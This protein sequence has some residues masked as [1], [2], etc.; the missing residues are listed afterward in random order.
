MADSWA[1]I[2]GKMFK[3]ALQELF[4]DNASTRALFSSCDQL[5]RAHSQLI[6]AEREFY[7]QLLLAE[8]CDVIKQGRLVN[9]FATGNTSNQEAL[10][11]TASV[12]AHDDK[13]DTVLRYEISDVVQGETLPH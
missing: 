5:I 7:Y 2:Y 12:G 1:C 10:E 11:S 9:Q 8:K 6:R 3:V 4:S 13:I